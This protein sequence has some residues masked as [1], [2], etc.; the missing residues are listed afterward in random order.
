MNCTIRFDG[1]TADIYGGMQMPTGDHAVAAKTLGIAPEKIKLHITYAGG[2]FGRRANTKSDYVL[3][4]CELAKIVKKPLKV[5]WS[6]EDDMRGGYYRPM[7]F[8]RVTLGLNASH[9]LNAWDHHIVGQSIMKGSIFESM[10]VKNGIEEA[11][12]EGV[13]DTPYALENFRLHQTRVDT[14]LTTLWWRSV[15]NTHTAYVM[16]TAIDELA[17]KAGHDPLEFRRHLLKKSPKHLAVLDLIQK[18]TGWGQQKPP[19]GRAWGL[20]I[21]ESFQSVVAHVAEVSMV[22][23]F[24]KVHRVWS[25]AHVGQ[26]VNPDGV[27]SQIEG[28]VVFGISAI[29]HQEIEVKDGAIVPGNYDLYPVLRMED[30]P[31]VSVHLVET[32]APPTGIG[33]PGVPPIGPA[34]ANAVYRLTHKRVRVLP[35]TKGLKA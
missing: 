13:K 20:A 17:E 25:A 6:R 28:G 24:P 11:V 2:S 35:F 16:E 29:L 18:A 4:A 15:G 31:L 33:E 22:N 1:E 19:P 30:T 5:V 23:G 12:I 32:H 10:M 7:N 14:P 27:A 21:H 34:V 8:H 3:E 26:V 9:Q